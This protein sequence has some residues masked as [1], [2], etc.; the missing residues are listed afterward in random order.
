MRGIEGPLSG[1]L[2]KHSRWRRWKEKWEDA[3]WPS[4][5]RPLQLCGGPFT[6]GFL[7]VLRAPPQPL[8]AL[9]GTLAHCPRTCIVQRKHCSQRKHQIACFW[10]GAVL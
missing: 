2:R 1:C 6:S 9:P 8:H 10:A 4:L 7:K 5:L 3:Q